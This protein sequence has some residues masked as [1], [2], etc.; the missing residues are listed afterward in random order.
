MERVRPGP[1]LIPGLNARNT[2]EKHKRIE[3]GKGQEPSGKGRLLTPHF[4]AFGAVGADVN[5]FPALQNA[6]PEVFVV[7]ILPQLFK[8][9]LFEIAKLV[10][11]ILVKTAWNHSPVPG[12]HRVMP[13]APAVVGIIAGKSRP[14]LAVLFVTAIFWVEGN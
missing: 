9:L 11:G 7:F 3:R 5:I 8:A 4:H 12:D 2:V 10:L 13:K 6:C 14:P 1:G